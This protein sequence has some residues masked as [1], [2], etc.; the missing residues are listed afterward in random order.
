MNLRFPG[1]YYDVE[2]GLNYNYFR[3]YNPSTGRYIQKDPISFAGGDI[4]LY[5]YVKENPINNTDSKELAIDTTDFTVDL[6]VV[7]AGESTVT[8]CDSNNKQHKATYHKF[9]VGLSLGATA[10]SFSAPQTGRTCPPSNGWSTDFGGA[11]GAGWS[12]S[13][14]GG[15]VS[16]GPTVGVG[17]GVMRCYYQ[18]WKDEVKGCCN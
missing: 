15:T 6:F 8:C 5:G 18:L 13:M 12:S 4:N 16:S 9:C 7:G 2:T 3:D 10:V 1:Q 17:G 11:L 14:G